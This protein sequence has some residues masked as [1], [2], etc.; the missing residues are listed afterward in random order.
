MLLA[1]LPL[2]ILDG[3]G[4]VSRG[5]GG[6]PSNLAYD[7]LN[8]VMGF[9]DIPPTFMVFAGGAIILIV[10]LT[11]H[12]FKNEPWGVRPLVLAGIPFEGALWAIPLLLIAPLFTMS[13]LSTTATLDGFATL[14]VVDRI[15]VSIS[16]GLYEELLFRMVGIALLHALFV[17]LCRM[18]NL[19]GTL[20]AIVGSACA[21][22][23]YHEPSLNAPAAAAF[24]LLAGLELGVLFVAR[25]FAIAV[26]THVLYNT[27]IFT[28][29]SNGT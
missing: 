27:V 20:L 18:K 4:L 19:Q 2:I 11:W 8:A 23:W 9:L 22:A 10:L 25:G 14:P 29:M 13:V 5:S 1:I 15:L 16:A 17:D 7:Q 28:T 3:I 12:L 21:F 26:W 6:V 24:Y